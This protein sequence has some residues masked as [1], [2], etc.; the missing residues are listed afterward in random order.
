MLD[1]NHNILCNS[2]AHTVLNLNHLEFRFFPVL[3]KIFVLCF[4]THT[5]DLLS[6]PALKPSGPHSGH[7]HIVT[8]QWEGGLLL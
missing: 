6:D 8:V 4:N 2:S 5:C 1:C 3:D 7:V